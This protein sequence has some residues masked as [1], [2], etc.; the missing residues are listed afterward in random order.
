MSIQESEDRIL[1]RK[2]SLRQSVPSPFGRNRVTEGLCT[3]AAQLA[4]KR[5]AQEPYKRGTPNAVSLNTGWYRLRGIFFR[6]VQRAKPAGCRF[7]P[8]QRMPS[9]RLS[10]VSQGQSRLV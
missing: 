7:L 5:L 6:V 3:C 2:D 4:R 10:G 1:N 9:S 8:L